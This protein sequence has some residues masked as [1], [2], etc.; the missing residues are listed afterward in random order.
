MCICVTICTLQSISS[1]LLL[2]QLLDEFQ[3]R[4]KQFQFSASSP[5]W[6]TLNAKINEN[7]KN[8]EVWFSLHILGFITIVKKNYYIFQRIIKHLQHLALFW[9]HKFLLNH[10]SIILLGITSGTNCHY[11]DLI[12]VCHS[13]ALIRR[14]HITWEHCY[15]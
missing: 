15:F 1:A 8:V 13:L 12:S 4:T 7:Q 14:F 6:E 9:S 5:W 10:L 3:R 2:F 11:V